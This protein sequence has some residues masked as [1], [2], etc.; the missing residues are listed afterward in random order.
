MKAE[1]SRQIPQKLAARLELVLLLVI[2]SR[3]LQHLLQLMKLSW[4]ARKV[5]TDCMLCRP[6]VIE[7]KVIPDM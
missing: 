4:G 7:R 3:T 5:L 6:D 1:T 2:Q